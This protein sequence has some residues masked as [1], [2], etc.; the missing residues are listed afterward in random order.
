M[1]FTLQEAH[2]ADLV[3]RE[4]VQHWR[5][6]LTIEFICPSVALLAQVHKIRGLVGFSALFF[7]LFIGLVFCKL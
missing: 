6:K 4:F 5:G 1:E 7:C 3:F 2:P